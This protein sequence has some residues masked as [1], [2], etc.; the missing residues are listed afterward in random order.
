MEYN[1]FLNEADE[2]NP[3]HIYVDDS[4]GDYYYYDG[5]KLVL[6]GRKPQIGDRG[7]QE[8]EIFLFRL[9]ASRN[10]ARRARIQRREKALVFRAELWRLNGCCAWVYGVY[11]LLVVR[12]SAEKGR[13]APFL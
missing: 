10:D 9:G 12:I 6:M 7:N 4:T 11:G 13:N 8:E 5:E 1:T 3:V 2:M